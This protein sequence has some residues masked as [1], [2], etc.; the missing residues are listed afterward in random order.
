MAPLEPGPAR[1][2]VPRRRRRRLRRV[3]WTF[4]VIAALPVLVV[5]GIGQAKVRGGVGDVDARPVAIVP[6]AGLRP[7]GEPSVYLQRRLDAAREL[8]EAG[9][10]GTILVSGDGSTPYHDEPTAMTTWLV[11]QG[12]PV[13][14]IVA[15]PG[16]LDTHD[17][18]VRA[19]DVF[20]V[21][22]A[23]VV[24]QDYHLR[25]ALFSCVAAGIDAVGVGVSAQSV[26]PRQA[27]GWRL[28]ELPASWKAFVDAAVRRPPAT[29]V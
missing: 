24:T 8:Y 28:R 20:G 21:D 16:G 10:V 23:V 27:F 9:A 5:Q 25:R 2:A 7:G 11:S 1:S 17:T 14:A 29:P 15:D 22:S 13:E 3:V 12:V 26:T 4:V 18:C 19:H 6:G